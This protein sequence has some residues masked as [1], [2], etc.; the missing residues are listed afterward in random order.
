MTVYMSDDRRKKPRV[1]TN[2]KCW[3]ER[4][5]VTLLGTVT[6]ISTTGLFLRTPVLVK[7]GAVVE[8]K[9]DFG[10]DI[11]A[12]RGRVVWA[13]VS[14]D[15]SLYSGIGIRFDSDTNGINLVKKAATD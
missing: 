11:V 3:L 8:L 12:A 6:N 13:N 2:L 1:A 4:E 10:S 5:S 7:N 14:S 15:T 9:I